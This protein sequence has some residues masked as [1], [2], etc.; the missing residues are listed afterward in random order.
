MR[1]ARFSHSMDKAKKIVWRS[2]DYNG[3]SKGPCIGGRWSTSEEID[4][5]GLVQPQTWQ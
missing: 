1:K 2:N 4:N 5:R 3:W